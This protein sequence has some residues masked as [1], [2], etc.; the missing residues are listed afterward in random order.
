MRKPLDFT[1]IEALREHMLIQVGDW[2]GILGV[3]RMT[4]YKWVNGKAQIRPARSEV[5]RQRIKQLL[6]V[7]A[8]G[9]PQPYIKGMDPKDRAV[10]LTALLKH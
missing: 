8:S 4:Y 6:G 5:V 7:M 10:K 1:K 3:S 9:W 2:V